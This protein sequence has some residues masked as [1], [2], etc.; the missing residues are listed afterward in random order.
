MFFKEGRIW[1]G[2]LPFSG[3]L[4]SQGEVPGSSVCLW[5]LETQGTLSGCQTSPGLFSRRDIDTGGSRLSTWG[6]LCVFFLLQMVPKWIEAGSRSRECRVGGSP[7]DLDYI[8]IPSTKVFF[9]FSLQR[10]TSHNK[11]RESERDRG[12]RERLRIMECGEGSKKERNQR[13]NVFFHA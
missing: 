9:F 10:E 4:H 8:L 7:R 6:L 5:G 3:P 1:G 11:I 12:E 2:F 13:R